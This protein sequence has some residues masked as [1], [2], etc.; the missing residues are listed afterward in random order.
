[1]EVAGNG[2]WRGRPLQK[3]IVGGL[4]LLIPCEDGG[5]RQGGQALGKGVGRADDPKRGL[6]DFGDLGRIGED[7]DDLLPVDECVAAGWHFRH[8]RADQDQ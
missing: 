2:R 4:R 7:M 1:M 6:I 3:V 5:R 8:A